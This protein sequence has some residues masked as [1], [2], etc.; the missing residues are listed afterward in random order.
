MSILKYEFICLIFNVKKLSGC[1]MIFELWLFGFVLLVYVGL[2]VLC[3]I[4]FKFF[5]V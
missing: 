1:G 3:V 4:L 5:R 2:F